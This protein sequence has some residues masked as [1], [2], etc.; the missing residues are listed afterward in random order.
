MVGIRSNGP[1]AE[2]GTIVPDVAREV[3]ARSCEIKSSSGTEIAVFEPKRSDD[4][5]QG[6]FIAGLLVEQPMRDVPVGMTY[7]EIE[8]KFATARGNTTG[9]KDLHADLLKWAACHGYKIDQN[10]YI[11]EIYFPADHGEDVEIYLP[12]L[13]RESHPNGQATSKASDIFW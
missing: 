2:F 13:S 11:V 1:F 12:L 8:G 5:L 9:L 7:I 6:E 3:M 10:E 4:H